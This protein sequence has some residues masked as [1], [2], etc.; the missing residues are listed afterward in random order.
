MN[1]A[2]A[3]G[4]EA[5]STD[6]ATSHENKTWTNMLA[7][8]TTSQ[9]WV[10]A[11]IAAVRHLR[12]RQCQHQD[13]GRWQHG[14]E[15]HWLRKRY[16]HEHPKRRATAPAS[17]SSAAPT[18][19]PPPHRF[20]PTT[21]CGKRVRTHRALHAR[22]AAAPASPPS[23]CRPPCAASSNNA[24][25]AGRPTPAPSAPRP[26]V[27]PPPGRNTKAT[28]SSPTRRHQSTPCRPHCQRRRRRRRVSPRAAARRTGHTL[29]R[30]H[31]RDAVATRCRHRRLARTLRER[32]PRRPPRQRRKKGD[33]VCHPLAT[34]GCGAEEEGSAPFPTM[35]SP[36]RDRGGWPTH[37]AWYGMWHARRRRGPS[38]HAHTRT[39]ML[40]RIPVQSLSPK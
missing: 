4:A 32:L 12:G 3:S 11:P 30:R 15:G 20:H 23:P 5:G 24:T 17:T 25:P 9:R 39:R 16:W 1:G 26:A 10:V 35:G 13:A 34:G 7:A 31:R 28:A 38:Y 8:A 37:H 33:T 2:R 29:P 21:S 19:C 36:R 18:A 27:P 14:K 40:R 6:E 22:A